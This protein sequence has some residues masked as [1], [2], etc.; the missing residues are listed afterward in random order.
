MRKVFRSVTRVLGF[1]VLTY[2]A[3]I[4]LA[5]LSTDAINRNDVIEPLIKF[6]HW[7]IDYFTPFITEPDDVEGLYITALV[8]TCWIVTAAVGIVLC[9]VIRR[10]C[11]R[12]RGT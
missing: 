9:V 11:A 6:V 8:L 3:A 12:S 5:H 10:F 7:F 4:G 1:I 2:I